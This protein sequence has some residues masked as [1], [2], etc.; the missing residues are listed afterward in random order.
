M[1]FSNSALMDDIIPYAS[2]IMAKTTSTYERA[3]YFSSIPITLHPPLLENRITKRDKREVDYYRVGELHWKRVD[4]ALSRTGSSGSRHRRSF[5]P[6][7]RPYSD[8]YLQP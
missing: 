5:F 6:N 8:E 4:A 2:Q 7:A 1:H 3:W